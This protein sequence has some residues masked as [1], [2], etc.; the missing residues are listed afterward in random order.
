MIPITRLLMLVSVF[1]HEHDE[2][3]LQTAGR[4]SL[5]QGGPEAEHLD[6]TGIPSS[7]DLSVGGLH[8]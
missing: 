5:I 3:G 4:E 8:A 7:S 6:L 2:S 1:H